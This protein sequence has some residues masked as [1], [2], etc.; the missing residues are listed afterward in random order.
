MLSKDVLGE[1]CLVQHSVLA[2]TRLDSGVISI[3][4]E[5]PF[6]LVSIRWSLL[7]Q[8]V[9]QSDVTAKHLH[10]DFCTCM[11]QL[12]LS[13]NDYRNVM[14]YDVI[15]W[16]CQNWTIESGLHS[17]VTVHVFFRDYTQRQQWHCDA[18]WCHHLNSFEAGGL[19]AKQLKLLVS[20]KVL[21]RTDSLSVNWNCS[22][23]RYFLFMHW[24]I[25]L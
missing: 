19:F 20:S 16:S 12:C 11:Q 8:L 21:H 14:Y 22:K 25:E 1:Q 10:S 18:I 24:A 13:H 3:T 7:L 9:M 4:H 5:Q 15:L 6:T 2:P 23:S 17:K